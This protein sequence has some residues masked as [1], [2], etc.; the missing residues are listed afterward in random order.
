MIY[1]G[2]EPGTGMSLYALPPPSGV[3]PHRHRALA[4]H[5]RCR[6][7][8]LQRAYCGMLLCRIHVNCFDTLRL[9]PVSCTSA[10]GLP[11]DASSCTSMQ[12]HQQ[13][14]TEKI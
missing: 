4:L 11:T 9:L 10:A 5:A 8:K 6:D 12:K 13:A 14:P 7:S 2:K 3:R 1:R